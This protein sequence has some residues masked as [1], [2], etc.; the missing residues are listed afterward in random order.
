MFEKDVIIVGG[1]L[2]GAATAWYLA[3]DGVSVSLIERGGLGGEASGAN[4]GSLHAQ[5]PADP[6]RNLGEAWARQF[7]PALRLYVASLG[8][9]AGLEAELGTDLEIGFGGGLMV[10]TSDAEMHELA[11]KA[12]IERAAGLD[13]QLLGA[14][15]VH[16][17]APYLS[18]RA[19]G[20]AFCAQEGKANPML[21]A[22]S[23]AAAAAACGA[24][25]HIHQGDA[26]ISRDGMHYIVRAAGRSH[27]ARRIVIA[28][29]T[30]T[31]ALLAMLGVKLAIEA[32]PIQVSVTE[33]AAAFLPHLVYCAGEKL[34]M[35]Q[36][37]IGSVLIGGGWSA[38][39]DSSGRPVVDTE[40]LA[41]NL[42]IACAVVP[43]VATLCL[44][45]TWA[46]FVNG[47]ADWLPILGPLPGVSGAFVNYV[48][49]LG[50]S[51]G[52]AAARALAD[53]VQGRQPSIDAPFEA[54][55]PRA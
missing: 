27:R 15:E 10:A 2:A 5:I 33:P 28:G 53:M 7:Q 6:F 29:G 24:E 42:R 20:G 43:G 46:A 32:F 52:P 11:R 41:A 19:V 8:M 22:P 30:G 35:K 13:V 36:T 39:L 34:T 12:E 45:R 51:G 21:V 48:P 3:R 17:R 14:Q 4:A 54:F 40:S 23:L 44:F 47:T 37:R 38:R 25:I 55:A 16:A 9:W 50:F 49:W 26:T 18:A 1:G 31:P